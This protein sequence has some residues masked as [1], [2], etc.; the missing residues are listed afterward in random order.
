MMWGFSCKS[1]SKFLLKKIFRNYANKYEDI[2]DEFFY[3]ENGFLICL[4]LKI[5]Y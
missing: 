2:L 4:K 3:T 5:R 1:F